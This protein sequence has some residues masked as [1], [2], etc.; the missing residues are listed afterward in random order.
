M[1]RIEFDTIDYTNH[2]RR[3]DVENTDGFAYRAAAQNQRYHTK[4]LAA[5]MRWADKLVKKNP[6]LFYQFTAAMYQR[7][8]T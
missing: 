3:H 2:R 6:P 8:K 4:Y 5:T 7:D 1:D